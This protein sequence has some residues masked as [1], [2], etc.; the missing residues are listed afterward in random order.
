MSRLHTKLLTDH[1]QSPILTHYGSVAS[2]TSN[3]LRRR[4]LCFIYKL[5]TYTMPT[6]ALYATLLMIWNILYTSI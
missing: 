6:S 5:T 3:I 4:K 1:L 2:V